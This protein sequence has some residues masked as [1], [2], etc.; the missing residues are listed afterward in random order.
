MKTKLCRPILLDSDKYQPL[1]FSTSK[2]GGLFNSE[3]YSPMK[4][5]GDTYK[6][7]VIISLDPNDKIEAGDTYFDYHTKKINISSETD[8]TSIYIDGNFRCDCKKV[9]ATQEQLSPEYIQQFIKE[10][11]QNDIK[12]I[13]IEMFDNGYEVD[14]EGIGGEDIGWMP[15]IEPKLT[16]GFITIV[17]EKLSDIDFKDATL[18]DMYD[19]GFPK[20][21]KESI[22][23]TEEEVKKLVNKAFNNARLKHKAFDRVTREGNIVG[24]KR[25]YIHPDAN[26]WFEQNKKK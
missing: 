26:I 13:E 7:L 14:M 20:V 12:D 25:K 4:E 3:H 18:Q 8:N 5:M 22:T 19:R 2:Y 1:V 24:Q 9:I 21:E 17:K 23:Y 15:K 11:N 16:N 10:Y 6:Q